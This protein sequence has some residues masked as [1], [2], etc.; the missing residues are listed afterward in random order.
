M[1]GLIIGLLILILKIKKR[2][3]E[4][5]KKMTG[6]YIFENE[7]Q[8][9]KSTIQILNLRLDQKNKRKNCYQSS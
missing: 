1:I 7:W 6:D 4:K 9:F 8:S 5:E 3:F 2:L